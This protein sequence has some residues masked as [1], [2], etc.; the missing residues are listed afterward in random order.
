[1]AN[2]IQIRRGLKINLPN[3]DVGEPAI[4][5]DT[6]EVFIGNTGGNVP[7]IN[8]D[9]LDAHLGNYTLQIPYGAASGSA[10]S[11]LVTLNPA[12]TSYSEG[13]AVAAKINVNNTGAATIN[14]NE[15]GAKSIR[16]SKGN[17]L[18]EGKLIANSI[19]TLRYN[20]T[21]FI[22]QGEGASGNATASDLLSGKTASTD[23]GDIIG[24]MPNRA[25]DNANLAS[26][27]SSTTLKLRAPKGYYDGAGDTVTITDSD[28]IASNIKSGVNLFGITGTMPIKPDDYRGSPG[29]QFLTHGDMTSGGYFGKHTGICTGNQLASAAGLSAGAGTNFTTSNV[30]WV[31]F[32]FEDKVLFIATKPLRRGVSWD[33]MNAVGIVMG[34]KQVTFAGITY[35]VRNVRVGYSGSGKTN[36]NGVSDMPLLKAVYNTYGGGTWDQLS[37]EELF[38]NITGDYDGGLSIGQETAPDRP[39]HTYQYSDASGG[40]TCSK[41]DAGTWFGWRPV[42]EVV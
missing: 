10:N 40:G 20:G 28:F 19:Y 8:K 4:C 3:L 11:Y 17:A 35:K 6:K 38:F 2:K 27:I 34:T 24:T 23:A 7:L 36:E 32:G 5:T 9:T 14:V 29:G 18:T 30:I 39:D 37:A 21:N 31:K 1:M 22:L 12:M 25:G 41:N 42:L 26:S 15:L 13:V 16:D 33:Q